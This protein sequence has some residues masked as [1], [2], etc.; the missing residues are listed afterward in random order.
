MILFNPE[1]KRS[2]PSLTFWDDFFPSSGEKNKKTKQ[3]QKKLTDDKRYFE[4]ESFLQKY[5]D[6]QV[7]L[8]DF[9]LD[10]R[11]EWKRFS[12]FN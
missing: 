6:I 7:G 3:K 5:D 8:Q 2:I 9:T 10:K 12:L 11:T 1:I 4:E